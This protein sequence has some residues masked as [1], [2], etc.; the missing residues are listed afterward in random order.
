VFWVLVFIPL[1]LGGC[2]Y[3]I[4]YN[5]TK[6]DIVLSD[7]TKPLKV[8]VATFSDT[9]D[10]VERELFARQKE[11]GYSFLHIVFVQTDLHNYTYDTQFRGDVAEGITKMLIK[12]LNYSKVFA[13]ETMPASFTTAQL[14]AEL[15]DSLSEAGVDAIMTGEIGHFYGYYED[16]YG[17]ELLYSLL[18][19]VPIGLFLIDYQPIYYTWLSIS[20]VLGELLESLH[21]RSIK[22]HVKIKAKLISTTTHQPLW[23]DSFDIS[24]DEQKSMPG[25]PTTNRRFQVAVWSLRDAVNQMVKSLEKASLSKE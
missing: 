3:P 17:R 10:S 4:M 15:L 8:Q 11:E 7:S 14:S 20:V 18:L 12:H 5:L 13:S 22:Q 16:T 1:F 9:R 23:E 21:K 2:G 25:F 24:S 19:G 6:K